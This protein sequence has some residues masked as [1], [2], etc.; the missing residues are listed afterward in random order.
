VKTTRVGAVALDV[1]DPALKDQTLQALRTALGTASPEAAD[2]MLD[3]LLNALRTKDAPAVGETAL[4]GALA[5]LHGV[6]PRDELEAM[7]VCQ[8]VATHQAA[9]TALRRVGF[10]ETIPQQDS[11]GSLAAKLLR[12]YCMQVEA[13]GRHR[14]QPSHRREQIASATFSVTRGDRQP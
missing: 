14:G 4:N 11:N 12:T 9:M 5:V 1:A 6:A 8:M 3:L 2:R 7:L 13:L 10:S